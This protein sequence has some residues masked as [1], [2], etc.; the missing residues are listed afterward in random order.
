MQYICNGTTNFDEIWYSDATVPSRYQQQIKIHDLEN[1]RWRR[2]PSWI[3]K[4]V[5]CYCLTVSEGPRC[6]TVPNIVE[7][8][9]FFAEILRFFK[10]SRWPPPPFSIFE[11]IA[12]FYWLLG[13]R[14]SRCASMPNFIIIGQLVAKFLRFFDV[15]RWRP[16]LSWIFEIVNFL[17]TDGIWRA[18]THH[19]TKFC[20]NRLFRCGDIVIFR[21]FKMATVRHLGFVWAYW[22]HPP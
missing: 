3:F 1:P 22:D 5:K 13:R 20:Q 17:F 14:L 6:I 21:F 10:F 12:K 11:K 7:I 4:F 2:P 18:Q 19:C 15:S 9:R 8:G 16:P